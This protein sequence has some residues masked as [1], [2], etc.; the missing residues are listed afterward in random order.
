M[1]KSWRFIGGIIL[2]AFL[3]LLLEIGLLILISRL[4][5]LPKGQ[6]LQYVAHPFWALIFSLL[7]VIIYG[8]AAGRKASQQWIWFFSALGLSTAIHLLI[9]LNP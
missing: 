2:K 9:F 3:L 1:K 6:G 4:F 7:S 5:P 8:V